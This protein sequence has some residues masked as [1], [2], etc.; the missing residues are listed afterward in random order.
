MKSSIYLVAIICGLQISGCQNIDFSNKLLEQIDSLSASFVPVH[1]E[2]LCD[3]DAT[4]T[5]GRTVLLKGKTNLPEARDA[6]TALISNEGFQFIDSITV[7]PDIMVVKNPWGLV[8][9][10]V[11]N[12]RATPSHAAEQVTQAIMGT[13]VKILDKR[14]GWLFIQTP[15]SYLGWTNDDAIAEYSDAEMA[16]WRGSDRV[17][18][19]ENAGVITGDA[20]QIVSDIVMGS[21]LMTTG[22]ERGSY[23][24]ILPDGRKGRIARDD[25]ADFASWAAE[26]QPQADKLIAFAT[27]LLGSPYLWGGTSTKGID[28]SGFVKITYFTAGMILARD[29]SAQ[30]LHGREIPIENTL[31]SLAPGDLLF[32]GR[33]RDGKKRIGHTGMYIGDTEVIHS[34]GMVKINSLDTARENYSDYLGSTILGAKRFIGVPPEKGYMRVSQHN[35]YF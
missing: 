14:G 17:I 30:Y 31:D 18:Y 29:A 21:V 8:T 4:M 33:M 12:M 23:N 22:E 34:S 13:P 20:G 16:V 9:V 35:W 11:C 32:F 1:A 6:I 26:Q 19:N 24:V 5:D 25:M 7:L 3:I 27:S 28:C 2:G 10:S 15:D